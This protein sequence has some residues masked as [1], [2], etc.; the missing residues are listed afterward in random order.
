ML[1]C[2][3]PHSFSAWPTC[4]LH[5][6][7]VS[8]SLGM[9]PGVPAHSAFFRADDE[10]VSQDLTTWALGT[11]AW[12]QFP[13][14]TEPGLLSSISLPSITVWCVPAGVQNWGRPLPPLL[15]VHLGES[16]T[17]SR[18]VAWLIAHPVPF[19]WCVWGRVISSFWGSVKASRREGVT[20]NRW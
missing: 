1:L 5:W 17:V 8:L 18:H 3:L 6:G 15:G 19:E 7:S 14:R 2:L 20:W 10:G 16:K 9:L 4:T 11:P 12:D 13:G